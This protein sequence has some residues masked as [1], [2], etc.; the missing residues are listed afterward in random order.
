MTSRQT[1]TERPIT[2]EW[3]F[4]HAQ[5]AQRT[6][7]HQIETLTIS[8]RQFLTGKGKGGRPVT[9]AGE[10]RIAQAPGRSPLVVL[11]HGSSGFGPNIELW[12]RYLNGLGISTFALDGFT[13]RGL[14]DVNSNQAALGRLNLIVDIYRA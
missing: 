12:S 1:C 9:I 7:L 14:T 6:E 11:Q 13:A 10:L 5:F 4:A 8:D 3:Q 2:S